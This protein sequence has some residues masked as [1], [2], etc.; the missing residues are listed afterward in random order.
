MT[1]EAHVLCGSDAA[2][3]DLER[4]VKSFLFERQI[5]AL[6][7]LEVVCNRGVVTL[8]G[9]VSSFYEKQIAISACQRVAGV[10]RLVDA[11]QVS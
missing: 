11:V 9:Q 3:R 6:R 1:V 5:W 8:C 7:M 10:R 4:R 2:D